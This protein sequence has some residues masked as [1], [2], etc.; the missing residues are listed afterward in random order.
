MSNIAIVPTFDLEF[1]RYELIHP[2]RPGQINKVRKMRTETKGEEIEV[3]VM[4]LGMS[5]LVYRFLD[6]TT[7]PNLLK[8]H[9]GDYMTNHNLQYGTVIGFCYDLQGKPTSSDHQTK[10]NVL[11]WF[12]RKAI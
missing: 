11:V 12:L 7:N 4:L 5:P 8:N 1:S 10:E 2:A 9:A 3:D 6:I